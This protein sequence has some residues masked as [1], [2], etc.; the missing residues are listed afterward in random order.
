VAL[1]LA[2]LSRL[3]LLLTRDSY[4]N[5]RNRNAPARERANKE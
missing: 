1:T 2:S 4:F 5:K 3:E